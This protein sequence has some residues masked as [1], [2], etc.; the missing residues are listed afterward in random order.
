MNLSGFDREN[1]S[2]VGLLQRKGQ[3]VFFILMKERAWS[4]LDD[5]R[6]NLQLLECLEKDVLLALRSDKV[7]MLLFV[8]VWFVLK[9]KRKRPFVDH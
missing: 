6:E 4:L 2:V 7:E 1:V 3:Q 9:R 8:A 5:C